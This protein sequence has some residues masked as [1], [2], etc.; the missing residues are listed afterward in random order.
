MTSAPTV[1]LMCGLPASGKTTT[2][3]RIHAAAGGVLI[4][5]C[6]VWADLGISLPAWVAATRGFTENVGAYERRRDEAYREMASRLRGALAG[7][8]RFVVVDAVHGERDKRAEV[9]RACAEFGA[10]PLVVWCRCDDFAETRR[11]FA[12][13]AGREHEGP[14]EASDLSV[15]RHIA[16]LWSDPL[17]E[18]LPDGREVPV[19]IVDT[20][21]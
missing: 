19:A 15:F 3:E 2:A 16:S 5:S 10:A 20:R 17:G 18:R 1:V 11:R 13:R 6:D 7:G 4:R 21:G 12:R 9:Y 14:N 8:A